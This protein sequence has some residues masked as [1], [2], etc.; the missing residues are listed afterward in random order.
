MEIRG[1][2][3]PP[4]GYIMIS[5]EFIEA[6]IDNCLNDTSFLNLPNR[7]KGKV[8]DTFDLGDKLLLVT[9]DRQSAFDRILASIPFKRPGPEPSQLILVRQHSGHCR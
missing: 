8:R 2:Q 3:R 9:T 4:L 1:V 7:K 6:N 5:K